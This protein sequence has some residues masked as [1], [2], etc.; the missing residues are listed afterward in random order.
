[1]NNLL[2]SFL[3]VLSLFHGPHSSPCRHSSALN[4]IS[5]LVR[6]SQ[7]ALGL[8]IEPLLT[9]VSTD[10]TDPRAEWCLITVPSPLRTD[11]KRG[12]HNKHCIS[13]GY[14]LVT[15]H[16]LPILNSICCLLSFSPEKYTHSRHVCFAG[17]SKFYLTNS[18]PV[19]LQWFLAINT[20]LLP[21]PRSP[22]SSP[23]NQGV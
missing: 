14:M 1:M 17:I 15:G 2:F 8:P 20:L 11:N 16:R 5:Y 13:I 7:A 18:L 9:T 4:N 3:A 10:S 21:H 19:Q 22:S 6:H 12:E 23:V